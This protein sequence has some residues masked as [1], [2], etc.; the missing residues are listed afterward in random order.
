M[1]ICLFFGFRALCALGGAYVG[2]S[3]SDTPFP[4]VHV[5]CESWEARDLGCGNEVKRTRH[6]CRFCW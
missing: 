5:E 3:G 2:L 4:E 6:G 1:F